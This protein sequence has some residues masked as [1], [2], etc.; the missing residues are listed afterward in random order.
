M[1]KA[2]ERL[3]RGHTAAKQAA[4]KVVYFVI[5]SEARNLSSIWPYEKKER[6]LASL[7]MTKFSRVFFRRL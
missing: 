7:G 5:R 2:V 4:E 6:F 1:K 3:K